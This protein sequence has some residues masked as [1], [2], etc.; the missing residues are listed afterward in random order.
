MS[1]PVDVSDM[2]RQ[3]GVGGEV[4][5][6]RLQTLCKISLRLYFQYNVISNLMLY[7]TAAKQNKINTAHEITA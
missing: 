3:W 1:F 6:M 2:S 7:V 4:L 5:N